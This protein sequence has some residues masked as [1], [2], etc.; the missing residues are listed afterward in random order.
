MGV[1]VP[2]NWKLITG[3]P[4]QKQKNSGGSATFLISIKYISGIE[5]NDLPKI[6]ISNYLFFSSLYTYLYFIPFDF[7]RKLMQ[8]NAIISKENSK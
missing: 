6:C 3:V 8:R 5:Y 2:F 4:K 1:N 7:E